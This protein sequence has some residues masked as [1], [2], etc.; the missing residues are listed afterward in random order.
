MTDD[1]YSSSRLTDDHDLSQF[2][3]GKAELNDW[4]VEMAARACQSDIARVYVWTVAGSQVVVGYFALTPTQVSRDI[5]STSVA[6][7]HT[8]IPGFLIARL[9]L[10][11]SLHG[12]GFGKQL[13]LNAVEN[14]LGASE[15]GAGRIV[16]VDAIDE[17]AASFY[18]KF[19]FVS[20]KDRSS[21]LVM[22]MK[23]VRQILGVS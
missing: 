10:D 14:A 17:D 22:K 13:L 6:G 18:R 16:V 1:R 9:A 21:R 20:V 15:V 19:G 11:K 12:T 2:D 23:T 8:T 3:C 7:G 4:L 5:V